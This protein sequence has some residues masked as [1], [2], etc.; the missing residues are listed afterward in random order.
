[1]WISTVSNP[2]I[3]GGKNTKEEEQYRDMFKL[4]FVT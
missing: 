2:L 4:N 3:I 1:M